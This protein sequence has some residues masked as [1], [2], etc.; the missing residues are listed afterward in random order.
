MTI[1][2]PLGKEPAPGPASAR[3]LPG[4]VDIQREDRIFDGFV[5]IYEATLR[6][7]R[8]DGSLTRPIK[9]IRVERGDSAA[10]I[11]TNDDTGRIVLVEQFR[12]PTLSRGDGWLVETVAGVVGEGET[13]EEAAVREVREEIGYTTR[14]LHH[15]ATFYASPGTS[16][17]RILLYWARVAESG[18]VGRVTDDEEDIAL[19]Q[20]TPAELWA[21]LDA[22]QLAD[23]KTII[24]ATLLRSRID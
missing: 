21:A 9:R 15:L 20:Y 13:A 10:A 18:H 14:S 23:A 7:R 19:R 24:A 5:G 6:H 3:C 12:Y 16:S 11:V 8:Y 2:L 17:E 4:M 22:G 1:P